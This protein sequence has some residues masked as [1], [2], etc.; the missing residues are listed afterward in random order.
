MTANVVQ[1]PQ[2]PLIVAEHQDWL[3]RDV[4]GHK[5]TGLAQL[6]E[7]GRVLP[8]TAEHRPTF[9]RVDLR[10][11]VP[12]A[13]NGAGAGERKL[14]VKWLQLFLKCCHDGLLSRLFS[15]TKSAQATGVGCSLPLVDLLMHEARGR[16]TS[17]H[18]A[19]LM[20]R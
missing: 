15:G 20:D 10:V 12:G 11:E 14:L 3:P 18:C 1:R 13:G 4:D 16:Q 5:R 7:A 9:E 19:C 2:G 8:G 6:I 17:R